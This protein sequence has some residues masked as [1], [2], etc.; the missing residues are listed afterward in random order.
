MAEIPGK[1]CNLQLEG[2][3]VKATLG[4]DPIRDSPIHTDILHALGWDL[5][6][7]DGAFTQELGYSTSQNGRWAGCYP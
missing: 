3:L 1:P 6:Q 2:H 5:P 7:A 4:Y